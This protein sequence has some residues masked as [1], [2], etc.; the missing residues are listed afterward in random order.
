M[1]ISW[2]LT[3]SLS[4]KDGTVVTSKISLRSHFNL[5]GAPAQLTNPGK[6]GCQ[7]FNRAALTAVL[8][9][10]LA[11]DTSDSAGRT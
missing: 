7:D 6:A 5:S 9:M 4:V 1:S 11:G 2:P 3:V 8:S 10:V